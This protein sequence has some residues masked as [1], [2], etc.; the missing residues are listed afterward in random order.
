MRRK[1]PVLVCFS[2]TALFLFL[3]GI[4][5]VYAQTQMNITH[6]F[7]NPFFLNPAMA[8]AKGQGMLHLTHRDQWRGI[9]GAPTTS[10][11]TYHQPLKYQRAGIGT[12]IFADNF[13]IFQTVGATAAFAYQA[14]FTTDTNLKF[15][16]SGGYVQNRIDSEVL[17]TTTDP[18][19]IGFAETTGY[20]DGRF[21]VNFQHKDFQLGFVV[22]KLFENPLVSFTGFADVE[23]NPRN[24]LLFTAQYDFEI[25]PSINLTTLGLY[26]LNDNFTNH[27][28]FFVVTDFYEAFWAGAGYRIEYG[29]SFLVGFKVSDF[30]TFG[31]AY[32]LAPNL[33]VNF[34]ASTHEVQVGFRIGS[35]PKD[36]STPRK[37]STV[38][39]AEPEPEPERRARFSAVETD[40]YDD[41]RKKEEERQERIREKEA[42]AFPSFNQEIPIA[43][44]QTKDDSQTIRKD[45]S[46]AQ[47]KNESISKQGTPFPIDR[48]DQLESDSRTSSET[49]DSR[50]NESSESSSPQ[51]GKVSNE[52]PFETTEDKI[53]GRRIAELQGKTQLSEV[54]QLEL[55]VLARKRELNEKI[56]NLQAKNNLN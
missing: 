42:T 22:P 26:W 25:G 15:G 36:R 46:T 55:S 53:L 28:E 43:Q 7:N 5:T 38:V 19:V 51:K 9:D 32:E 39:A 24:N 14:N 45:E 40:I 27:S 49:A 29:P 30:M 1:L 17:A 41:I 52:E 54:E 23:F 11:L 10:I 16:L 2:L 37:T 6:H 12:Q 48:E 13:G 47:N 20:V 56:E 35:K 33:G 4:M 44:S 8:G 21:G 18:T 31:Y 50:E 3:S 34:G